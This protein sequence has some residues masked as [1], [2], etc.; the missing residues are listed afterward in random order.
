[1]TLNPLQVLRT[2]RAWANADPYTEQEREQ[3]RQCVAGDAVAA[4]KA[5]QR[6][7][8]KALSRRARRR[9]RSQ[10]GAS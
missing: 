9:W 2:R 10:G 6:P 7:I 4:W 1:M 8:V 3:L 5:A